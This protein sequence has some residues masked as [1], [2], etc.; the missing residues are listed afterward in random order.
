MGEDEAGESQVVNSLTHRLE[1]VG[2]SLVDKK[3]LLGRNL[4]I[5]ALGVKR[6]QNITLQEHL[7]TGFVR[8]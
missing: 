8:S 4:A 3:V 5:P 6:L 7:R 2:L 1:E